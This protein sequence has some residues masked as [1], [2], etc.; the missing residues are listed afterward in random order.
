VT[1]PVNGLRLCGVDAPAL[2]ITDEAKLHLGDRAE[3]SQDHAAHRAAGIDGRLQ[4]PKTCAFL[5]K[6]VREMRTSG[7]FVP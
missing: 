7:A 5:F 1:A 4:H 3:H 6:F 2:P